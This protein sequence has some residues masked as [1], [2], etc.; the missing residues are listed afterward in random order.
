MEYLKYII[1]EKKGA[2]SSEYA[3]LVALIA[4]AIIGILVVLGA[5]VLRLFE[6]EFPMPS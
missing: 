2:T 4:I 1:Q 6:F 5:L 3:I